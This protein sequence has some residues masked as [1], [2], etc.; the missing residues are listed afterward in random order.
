LEFSQRLSSEARPKTKVP[1][2]GRLNGF[3]SLLYYE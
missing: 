2:L 3:L 1:N